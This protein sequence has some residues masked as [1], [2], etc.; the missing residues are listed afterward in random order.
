MPW[1]SLPAM[2]ISGLEIIA[3]VTAPHTATMRMI[4]VAGLLPRWSEILGRNSRGMTVP[5]RYH[6]DTMDSWAWDMP[7]SSCH[8]EYSDIGDPDAKYRITSAPT[9][10]TKLNRALASIMT[11]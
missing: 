1:M 3:K 10:P 7:R 6:M 2:I 9:A 4:I 8:I 11:A 5:S